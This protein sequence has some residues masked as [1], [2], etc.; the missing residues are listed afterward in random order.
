MRCRFR[1]SVIWTLGVAL[2]CAP[3]SDVPPVTGGAAPAP[4]AFADTLPSEF[5]FHTCDRVTLGAPDGVTVDFNGV[6]VIADTSPPRLVSYHSETGVCQE[7]QAPSDRPAFRPSDVAVRGFFVYAVDEAN[8]LLLRWDAS[9]TYRDVLLSFEEL[10]ER[11]RVSPYGLD[12]DASGRTA[13]TDVENHQVI[14]LDTYLDVDVAFG[15]FGSFDGQLDSPQGVSFTPRGELLVADTGNARLQVFSDTG[16]FRRAIPSLGASS[17][18]RRPRRAV[19]GEDGRV[20]VADPAAARVF[21][22]SAEGGFVRAILADTPGLFTPTDLAL[23]RDGILF[24]T[25]SSSKTLYAI[26]VM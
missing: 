21:E 22:F 23:G 24:V 17:P 5:S 20:F 1:Q 16:A 26:K 6:V 14:V 11:R 7:F 13:I 9:G 25:D 2:S 19:A 15:N 8:R 10:A 3:A 12:V 4:T 18:M